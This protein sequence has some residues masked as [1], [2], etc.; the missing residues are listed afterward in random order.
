MLLLVTVI[1]IPIWLPLTALADV[2][3]EP[4]RMRYSRIGYLVLLLLLN[5]VST[6]VLLLAFWIRSAFGFLIRVP[7][8]Q[9]RLQRA[10]HYYARGL[11]RCAVRAVGVRL[12]VTGL[13]E[14]TRDRAP[15]VLFGHHTSLLDSA[16]PVELLAPKHRYRFRYVIKKTLAYG[17]AFDFGGHMLP[18]HFVD[19]TGKRT[20]DE[21]A[22]I[23]G[24][25]SGLGS[26][27]VVVLFPEGSF[28]NPARMKKSID[29]L[30]VDAPHLVSRAETWRHTLPP[31]AGGA[32][33]MIDGAPGVDVLML[34]HAGLESFNS[35]GN[36][37][38]NIPLAKPVRVHCWRVPASEIPLDRDA[39]YDWLFDQFELVDQF[40][41]SQLDVPSQ[42]AA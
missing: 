8:H 23:R 12:E 9:L 32:L 15:F 36:I 16:L 26:G 20:G 7:S 10:L 6:L 28:H 5:E 30:R 19:R 35:L 25:S 13:D 3:T 14:A 40:T 4:K 41:V 33:A 38:R 31:R 11:F 24:L 42:K 1:G 17:P 39:R 27:E 37:L 21:M 2:A 34:A 18:I 22:S 29:R